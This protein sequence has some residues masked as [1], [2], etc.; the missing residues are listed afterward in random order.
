VVRRDA[1]C[2][3][4]GRGRKTGGLSTEHAWRGA[5]PPGKGCGKGIDSTENT[6]DMKKKKD[7]D[8]KSEGRDGSE[9]IK[10]AGEFYE[11]MKKNE[12]ENNEKTSG[13]S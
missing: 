7:G 8:N 11:R 13:A 2:L 4:Q 3:P 12:K 1:T 5:E 10:S 6:V 9:E